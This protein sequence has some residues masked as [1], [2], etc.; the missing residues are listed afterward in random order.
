MALT[1]QNPFAGCR[2]SR[3]VVIDG[4]RIIGLVGLKDL[5][6][7]WIVNL[8][9]W[10]VLSVSGVENVILSINVVAALIFNFMDLRLD[11]KSLAG[12]SSLMFVLTLSCW[13][14]LR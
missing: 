11:I 9:R 10:W 4:G 7:S 2:Q 3:E 1:I 12:R 6:I 8:F 5:S 13:K 14:Q